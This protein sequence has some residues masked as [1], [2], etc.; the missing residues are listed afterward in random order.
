M[1]GKRAQKKPPAKG[2][3][4]AKRRAKARKGGGQASTLSRQPGMSLYGAPVAMSSGPLSARFDINSVS[5]SKHGEG[6]RI[7][8][9]LFAADIA[10]VIGESRCIT[11]TYNS[12]AYLM[13]NPINIGVVNS[14]LARIAQTYERFVFKGVRLVYSTSVGTNYTGTMGIFYIQDPLRYST[15]NNSSNYGHALE[16]PNSLMI[17]PWLANSVDLT[18]QLDTEQLCFVDG[19]STTD[20]DIRQSNQGVIIGGWQA[21][22]GANIKIG[23]LQMEYTIELYNPVTA[24]DI[25]LDARRTSPS[26]TEDGREEDWKMVSPSPKLPTKGR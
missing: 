14:R 25:A 8:G 5:H 1:S 2:A 20:A 6:L 10:G 17:T 23:V 19:G 3:P 18:R 9:V 26:K 11:S 7:S 16:T 4:S 22:A 13:L 21:V 12:A 15:A 24:L